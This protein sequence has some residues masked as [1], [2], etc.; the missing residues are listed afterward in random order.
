MG[1]ERESRATDKRAEQSKL[2]AVQPERKLGPH[3][4]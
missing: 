3:V 1:G 4:L 2:N